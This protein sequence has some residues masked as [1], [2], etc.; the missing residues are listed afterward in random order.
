MNESIILKT[1][2]R[3]GP[4]SRTDIAK[5]TGQ[6]PSTL[7][8]ITGKLLEDN[9]ILEHMVGES[10]GGR[11]PVLLRVNPDAANI[12]IINI[13]THSVCCHIADAAGD[14]IMPKRDY[15]FK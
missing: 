4:I 13:R 8:N 5:I 10:S 11:K 2:R 7:T 6:I 15:W 12:I 1:I 14:M 9:I 3:M